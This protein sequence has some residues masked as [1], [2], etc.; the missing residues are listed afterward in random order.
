MNNDNKKIK[1]RP[2]IYTTS[3]F[4]RGAQNT[5]QQMFLLKAM[6]VTTDPHELRKMLGVRT[7]AEV[8]RTL[9]KLAMRKEYHS[10]LARNGISFDFIVGGLKTEAAGGEKSADRIKALQVLL[11]SLGLDKYDNDIAAGGTWEEELLKTVSQPDK[12]PL[13]S[14]DVVPVEE[15]EVVEPPKPDSVTKKQAE[16]HEILKSIYE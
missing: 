13:P 5:A 1:L 7:V 4:K 15:Y 9:D 14:G 12:K 16:E 10:A 8:F 3:S 2:V 11:K 6:Q